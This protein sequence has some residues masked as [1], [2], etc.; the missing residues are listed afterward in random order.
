MNEIPTI[1]MVAII[2]LAVFKDLIN[3]WYLGIG[4]GLFSLLIFYA[5]KKAAAKMSS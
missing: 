3:W 1:L 4:L 2:F 5:V